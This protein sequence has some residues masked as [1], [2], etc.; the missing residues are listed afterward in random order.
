MTASADPPGTADPSSM[1]GPSLAAAASRGAFVTLSGQAVRFLLQL[2]GLVVLARLLT[3]EDYGL[4]AL[5]AVVIGL[6]ELF[7]DSGLSSAAVQAEVLTSGQRNN[8]FWL[9]TG[10]GMAMAVLACGLAP[11]LAS[12]VGDDRLTALTMVLSAVFV[13]NGASTQYRAMHARHLRFGRLAAAEISGQLV[14]LATGIVLAALGGGYWALVAQQLVQAS[15]TQL[16]LVL[17]SGWLPGRIARAESIR[18]FVG[19]GLPLL[20]SQL[21]NYTANHADTMVIGLRSGPASLGVYDRAFQLVMMPLLQVQ[22]PSTRVAL[23]VLSRLRGQPNRFAEFLC[24]G[25]IVLLTL[26]GSAF[27]VLFAQAPAVVFLVLGPQWSAAVPIFQVLLVAGFFR[28]AAYATYWVFLAE[29]LTRAQLRYALATRPLMVALVVVGSF[30]GVQGV[31]VAYM[32]GAAVAWPV[33]LLWIRK[34]SDA[35]AGRMFRN[36]LRTGVVFSLAAAV[37]MAGTA[38]LPADA[39]VLRVIAGAAAVAVVGTLA[40]LVWPVFRRDL[41]AIVAL[42]RHLHG[43]QAAVRS[44]E[45]VA[46][47]QP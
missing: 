17:S 10:I 40:A 35:P 42:R 47:G 43:T 22:A 45:P 26:V 7:R 9:N 33:A 2:G 25:Q 16:V 36:G 41:L 6:G 44:A 13:L 46:G 30:W 23:P 28:A 38:G 14:G 27:A 20:G 3:P 19:Y 5:V 24:F 31:A 39:H 8:L 34:V 29:G 18:S 12:A 21:L 1:A 32:V 11:V 15:A 37:S 4:V